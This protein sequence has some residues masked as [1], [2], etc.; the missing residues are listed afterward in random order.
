MTRSS[1]FPEKPR[2]LRRTL[3]GVEPF[4]N[5]DMESLISVS[6]PRRKWSFDITYKDYF[7]VIVRALKDHWGTVENL[8][9]GCMSITDAN[10]ALKVEIISEKHGSHYHPAR[11]DIKVLDSKLSLAAN[12]AISE[13][14]L[15]R[16]ETEYE[17][18]KRLFNGFQKKYIPETLFFYKD[19][20]IGSDH[21][22]HHVKILFTKWLDGYH[23]FHICESEDPNEQA[24]ILWDTE[25]GYSELSSAEIHDVYKRASAILTYYFNP[26][27]SEEIF[28]WHHG[29]GDFVA[30]RVSESVSVRLISVRQYT[31]RVVCINER[32]DPVEALITFFANLTIRMRLDRVD[33]IG[34]II[35]AN[36]KT[37]LACIE[38][39][40]KGL[41]MKARE[42]Q[43]WFELVE[44][45]IEIIAKMG[46]GDWAEV[47]ARVLDSY[48]QESPDDH[49]INEGIVDHIFLVYKTL[50]EKPWEREFKASCQ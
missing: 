8:L 16:I 49:A 18:M 12:V 45:L 40:F 37:L 3:N 33:G 26:Q 34:E 31:A 28:P 7:S 1:T 50:S 10:T 19:Q 6:G 48:D 21:N 24:L 23:E 35:W 27:T 41:S 20:F 2:L 22:N 29:A 14:G 39:F 5:E 32:L 9:N 13:P 42:M 44:K 36:D 46:P 4:D 17:A 47:F 15:S 25:I 43:R 11:I 38:G 30:R